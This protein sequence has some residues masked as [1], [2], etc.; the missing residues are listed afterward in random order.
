VLYAFKLYLIK[1]NF[2]KE[3]GLASTYLLKHP[4]PKESKSKSSPFRFAIFERY[5]RPPSFLLGY[6]EGKEGGCYLY[7]ARL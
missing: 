3:L 7:T 5:P 4:P 2:K 6:S 1:K